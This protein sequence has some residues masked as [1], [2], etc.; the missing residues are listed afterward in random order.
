M[1]DNHQSQVISRLVS[2]ILWSHVTV[3]T[4]Y[5]NKFWND[6]NVVCLNSMNTY[7]TTTSANFISLLSVE[8]PSCKCCIMS[9]SVS[10]SVKS[11]CKKTAFGG[12]SF[13]SAIQNYLSNLLLLLTLL[14][15]VFFTGEINANKLFFSFQFQGNNL[16]YDDE[17]YCCH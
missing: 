1:D 4:I 15:Q 9:C 13:I 8:S 17:K 6:S 3:C 7:L 10:G 2:T 12:T 16:S 11:R 14:F 5:V